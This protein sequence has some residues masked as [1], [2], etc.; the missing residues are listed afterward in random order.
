MRVAV[1]YFLVWTALGMVVFPLGVALAEIEMKQAALA[2]TVPIAVG[3][4]VLIAG[5]VQFTAWKARHL[6]CCR[7]A[8]VVSCRL[9][10]DPVTA[11][12]Y[13][14]RLGLHCSYCCANLTVILLVVGVMNLR[15]MAGVTVVIILE[16]LA[17]AGERIAR[18]LG[19]VIIGVGLF[20]IA[21]A[22]GVG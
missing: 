10:A 14:L 22:S 6:S 13:G 18:A 8:P 5:A 11:W 15:A 16:R 9:S 1:G 2:R 4:T 21:Q 20:L 7:T 17:P 3:L 19:A 12:R